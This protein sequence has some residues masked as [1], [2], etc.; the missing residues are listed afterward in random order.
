MT[1][2]CGLEWNSIRGRGG[3]GD[4]T[5]AL[6]ESL[7]DMQ[8]D[9]SDAAAFKNRAR[10]PSSL[11]LQV[12][13]ISESHMYSAMQDY[14]GLLTAH[15]RAEACGGIT[16]TPRASRLNQRPSTVFPSLQLLWQNDSNC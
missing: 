6:R 5:F 8:T 13:R 4:L 1:W 9:T 7:K 14:I 10:V 15:I 16:G 2:M 11:N 3:E 12:C